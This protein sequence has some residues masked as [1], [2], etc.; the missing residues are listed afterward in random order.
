MNENSQNF[1]TRLISCTPYKSM[2]QSPTGPCSLPRARHFLQQTLSHVTVQI[3]ERREVPR[4]FRVTDA[5]TKQSNE[6]RLCFYTWPSIDRFNW[7][8]KS[9]VYAVRSQ[10]TD[11]SQSMV[12]PCINPP[13]T[14]VNNIKFAEPFI[15][16]LTPHTDS[17]T[18]SG[19]QVPAN[20][21][22]VLIT[23]IYILVLPFLIS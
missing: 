1:Q 9:T 7:L 8:N 4:P 11:W 22:T 6:Y 20:A 16:G 23:V 10:W 13:I 5:G 19:K 12:W 2:G 15:C 18:L 17:I 21:T 14:F 3:W